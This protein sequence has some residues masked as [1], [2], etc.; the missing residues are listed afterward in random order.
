MCAG[1]CERACL[2]VCVC[3][4][5]C[6]HLRVCTFGVAGARGGGGG[7][8][9]GRGGGRHGGAEA[10]GGDSER[11]DVLL[12]LEEDDVDLGGEEAAQHHR[13]AQA[14]RDAHGGGLH[15]WAGHTRVSATS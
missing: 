3:V 7:G 10:V 6:M 15:L 2:G 14:D 11:G 8:G 1:G 4:F 9:G 12:G 5:A 13:A